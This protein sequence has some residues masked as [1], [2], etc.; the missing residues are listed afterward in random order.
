VFVPTR[1]P[2]PDDWGSGGDDKAVAASRVTAL[3]AQVAALRR[4]IDDLTRRTK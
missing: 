3:E 2:I 4:E 1:P